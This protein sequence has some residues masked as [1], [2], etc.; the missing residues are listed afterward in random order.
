MKQSVLKQQTDQKAAP[1]YGSWGSGAC[2]LALVSENP[3]N[4]CAP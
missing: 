1:A 2:M 3:P 4:Y